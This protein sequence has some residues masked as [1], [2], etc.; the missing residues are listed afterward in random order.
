MTKTYVD[1]S[2]LVNVG[3]QIGQLYANIFVVNFALIPHIVVVFPML[4]LNKEMMVGIPLVT[5]QSKNGTAFN[6]KI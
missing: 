5:E 2:E 6:L 4:N 1:L 3:G